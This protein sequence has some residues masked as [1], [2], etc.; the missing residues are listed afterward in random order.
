M[1][2]PIKEFITKHNVKTKFLMVGLWNTVFGYF[3]FIGFDYVFESFFS[4]RYIAYMSAAVLSNIIA[5]INAYVFHKFVT[6]KSR[7]KGIGIIFEFFRF[8]TTYLITFCL[9]LI[10]LPFLA[11]IM[12]MTTRIA[13]AIVILCCTIISYLGH[14]KFSF[15]RN[16]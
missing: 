9:S 14:S 8:S 10:L 12:N 16:F 13:G 15:K 7:I 4:K 2:L 11:E 1:R 6:F 3:V 5:I